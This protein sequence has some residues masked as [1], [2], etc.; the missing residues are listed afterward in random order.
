MKSVAFHTTKPFTIGLVEYDVKP[1]DGFGIVAQKT[2]GDLAPKVA[3]E[4]SVS[5]EFNAVSKGR[6][7]GGVPPAKKLDLG[8]NPPP[9]TSS[10]VSAYPK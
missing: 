5:I 9:Q 2:L 3:T 1:R 4:A 8:E 10:V 6:V 7:D